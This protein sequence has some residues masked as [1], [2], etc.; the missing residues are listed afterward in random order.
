MQWCDFYDAFWDW[1]DSTRRTRI[2]SLE[3]IGSGDE[4]VDA[5][6]E[7]EDPKVKAQLIRKAMKFGAEF[8]SDDFMNLDGELPDELY[9]ELGK[10][11]GFDHNDP[12]FDEDNMTWDDF[13]CCYS[14]WSEEL[15]ARRIEKLNE[16]GNSEAVSEVIMCMPTSELED[17]LYNRAVKTGVR[18]TEKQLENMGHVEHQLKNALDNFLTD[19]QIDQ[20]VANAEA[21]VDNY[22]QEKKAQK[23]IG[24]WGTIIGILSGMNQ[25]S[26]N[27][28]HSHKCNGDCANCPPHYG[29][30]YG[31][32]YY[33]H[34]HQYGC[35]RGGNGGAS[36][37]T[38]RD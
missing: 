31:R 16:F 10:Y 14:D 15:L 23:R 8:S 18:F 35:E 21:I 13:E 1:S 25:T 9:A 38:Y 3:D 27:H 29:Y 7:I 33:G 2:S 30:R 36:G 11:T 24:F 20:F 5:V 19:D 4:V 34:G 32:W 22:E 37:R 17:A 6:L 26:S 12:Y 28:A